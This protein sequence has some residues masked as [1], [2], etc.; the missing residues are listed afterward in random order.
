[1]SAKKRGR[2]FFVLHLSD[3]HRRPDPAV[4][5]EIQLL[6]RRGESIAEAYLT[7]SASEAFVSGVAVPSAVIAAARRQPLGQGDY[8]DEEGNSVKPF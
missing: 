5:Y 7:D 1:M 4:R 8:I 6:N 2:W 3:R